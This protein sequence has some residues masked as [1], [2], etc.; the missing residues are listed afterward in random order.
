MTRKRKMII[1]G[2]SICVVLVMAIVVFSGVIGVSANNITDDARKTQKIDS[3][4]EMNG[5]SNDEITALIFFNNTHD[6]HTFS[7]YLPRGGLSFGYFF[8]DGGSSSIIMNGIQ[9]FTYGENGSAIL[10]M[11]KDR[12]ARIVYGDGKDITEILVNPARPFAKVVP[13]NSG[14]ISLYSENGVE[15]PITSIEQRG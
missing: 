4:W 15:L 10:S 6:D 7:V 8:R 11:N 9:M 3:S 2:I 12:V 5:A 13:A 1:I 14:P